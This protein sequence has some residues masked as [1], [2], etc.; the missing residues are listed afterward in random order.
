MVRGGD[1]DDRA[2]AR[3]VESAPRAHLPKEYIR[4]DPPEDKCGIINEVRVLRMFYSSHGIY[5]A[6]RVAEEERKDGW[7][8]GRSGQGEGAGKETDVD[9]LL[10][11]PVQRASVHPAH[12]QTLNS[13]STA[14]S[15]Q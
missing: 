12:A 9:G 1:K 15:L 7:G 2:F 3:N 10:R 14:Y 11:A 6:S 5:E 13:H 8:C 4:D